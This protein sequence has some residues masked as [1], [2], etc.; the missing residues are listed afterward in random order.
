MS[1][2]I[3]STRISQGLAVA[4]VALVALGAAGCAHTQ[5]SGTYIAGDASPQGATL[6]AP[7]PKQ[8][9]SAPAVAPEPTV[10]PE[11]AVP[12]HN[13]APEAAP[14]TATV[15]PPRRAAPRPAPAAAPA[16]A[17]VITRTA[18]ATAKHTPQDVWE[19]IRHGFQMHGTGDPALVSDWE[20]YYSSKP[21]YFAQMI[22]NS[23]RFLYH[24]ASEVERRG[25]PLEIA[26]LPMIE[27]AYNPVAYSSAHA[28]GIWQFI[29]STGKHY[30]LKQNWWYDGR[31]DVIAA[32]GAAL[33]YLQTLYGMF[34][35]WELALA[36][37]NWGEGAV[38]RAIE[39]NQAK[40]L[41]TDFL[42]LAAGMPAETRNYLPKLLAVK[43][44]I[45]HPARFGLT[46]AHV[47]NE[48]YFEVIRVRR[49]IDVTLAARFAGMSLDEFKFLNPAHNKPVI[50][51]DSA[52]TL[53]LPMEKAAAF[54]AHMSQHETKPLVAMKTHTVRAGE[55]PHTIA[56]RYGLS[57]D[58][59]NSMNNIGPRRRIA[60]GQTLM[61][62]N[63]DLQPALDDMPVAT[64]LAE[65]ALRPV[66]YTRTVM[67]KMVVVRGGVRRTVTVAA[68]IPVA[69][70]GRAAGPVPLHKVVTPPRATAVPLRRVGALKPVA[71]QVKKVQTIQKVAYNPQP[72]K[73]KRH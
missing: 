5:T 56:E 3:R 46:L 64:H 59:L 63:A 68:R 17:P 70:P 11:A 37:Y 57:V 7:T 4:L 39:R 25:M 13:A 53:V 27:S 41:P 42:S 49:H 33:D 1:W 10:V 16:P 69:D 8:E 28:S 12:E 45:A 60:T 18:T 65:A 71:L 54:M 43:N 23:S 51:S 40:G 61:V 30:G 24:V 62:P 20:N 26:L 38:Q 29:P 9:Y 34:N 19:R 72:A 35:D 50:H 47:A 44:L 21:D 31:R 22:G 15:T 67:Q 14:R 58:E 52:E 36:A 32:T 66:V 48:P 2:F 55:L 73:A 6:H